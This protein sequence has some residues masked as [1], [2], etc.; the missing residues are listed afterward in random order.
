VFSA[1][2]S[3]IDS[4]ILFNGTLYIVTDRS[5]RWPSLDQISAATP[6]AEEHYKNELRFI[7]S[8]EAVALI[9]PLAGRYFFLS[10]IS[11]SIAHRL[12]SIDGVTLLSFDE[13][14]SK[15]PSRR[16]STAAH[17]PPV[18]SRLVHLNFTPKD[19]QQPRH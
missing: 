7:S 15:L 19:V 3:I 12:N 9:P 4:L 2:Y 6:S 11:S 1:G 13:V 10:G 17:T 16:V 18:R 8:E 14:K 5:T